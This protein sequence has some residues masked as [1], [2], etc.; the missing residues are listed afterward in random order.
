LVGLSQG[1]TGVLSRRE[2]LSIL[3]GRL[4]ELVP[5]DCIAF[6]AR[7]DTTLV[8]EFATGTHVETLASLKVPI[9]H[10]LSGW[11]AANGRAILNG[12]PSVDS[13]SLTGLRS[14]LAIPLEGEEDI[15]GVLT[16][17]RAKPDAFSAMDLLDL[18]ALGDALGDLMES[19]GNARPAPRQ[20]VVAIAPP[21]APRARALNRSLQPV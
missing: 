19:G 8:P 1:L 16:L 17:F 21:P 14:A 13:P 5:C 20:N 9:G 3:A 6:Y 2:V 11:V 18:S 12:N 4:Q 15:A 7:R 10:G